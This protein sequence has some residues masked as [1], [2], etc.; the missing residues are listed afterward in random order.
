MAHS[1]LGVKISPAEFNEI[2]SWSELIA[3]DQDGSLPE[4]FKG[5]VEE[6]RKKLEAKKA[7]I[8]RIRD[9]KAG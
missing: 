2:M 9:W 3:A 8:A 7:D 5:P 1:F 6:A 4:F